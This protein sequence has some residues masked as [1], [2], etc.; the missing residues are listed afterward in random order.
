MSF[1]K[2][3]AKSNINAKA[4][5]LFAPTYITWNG[6]GASNNWSTASNWD[7][8]RP[9]KRS[10]ILQFAGTTRTTPF[11]DLTIDS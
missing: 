6:S 3:L 9:P 4:I 10:D 5:F 1:V 7:I 2:L 8:A 11:N